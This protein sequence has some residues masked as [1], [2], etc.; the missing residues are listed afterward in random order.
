MAE[1]KKTIK[2]TTAAKTAQK[3]ATKAPVKAKPAVKKE[4]TKVEATVKVSEKKQTGLSVDVL[5]T[6]GKV[7]GSVS[8]PAEL[9]AGKVNKTLLSQAV[10]VYLLN[11][12][13]GTVDSK[14]RGEVDGSTRK[15]YR[16]KGT[17][18]ARH[19][20][21]RAPIFVKGGVAHGPKQQNYEAAMPQ[22]MR[23]AALVSALTAKLQAGEI[24]VVAGFEKIDK[25]T[26]SMVDALSKVHA[27]GKTLLVMPS[28]VDGTFKSARNIKNV[29]VTSANMV[30]TYALLHCNTVIL[31]KDAVEV[32]S[33]T[34][35]K[36]K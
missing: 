30:N 22:A 8:L 13:Q 29:T 23:R 16:Q 34:F 7:A 25:K 4:A 12:R 5:D 1:A 20:G 21:I 26:K 15:I 17:G 33:K 14:T 11:Q 36:A 2:K 9:F 10:R 32:M 6:A 35:G 28:H 31:M 27:K 19:G 3:A 18:R 24:T